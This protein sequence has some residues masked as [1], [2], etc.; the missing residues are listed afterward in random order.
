MEAREELVCIALKAGL[1]DAD[2]RFSCRLQ[3][4]S[5]TIIYNFM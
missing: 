3:V 4:A 2:M 1:V 5:K